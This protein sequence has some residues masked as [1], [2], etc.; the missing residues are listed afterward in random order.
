MRWLMKR[1]VRL[2][3]VTAHFIHSLILASDELELGVARVDYSE[4]PEGD[5]L[6][7]QADAAAASRAAVRVEDSLRLV[8]SG[9]LWR[10]SAG[11]DAATTTPQPVAN[12][13]RQGHRASGST[14][15]AGTW[16]RRWFVLR[17]DACLYF[18]KSE[19]VSQRQT[20]PDGFRQSTQSYKEGKRK[21]KPASDVETCRRLG[22]DSFRI[23]FTLW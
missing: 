23:L 16:S 8:H 14:P 11:H 9:Y 7:H 15:K 5:P 19:E 2:K 10:L 21:R 18:F 20:K 1:N 17:N 6:L 3:R 13:T 22:G 12:H 4:L